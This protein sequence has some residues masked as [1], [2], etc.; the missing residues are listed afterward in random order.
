MKTVQH[1]YTTTPDVKRVF[2]EFLLEAVDE[3]LSALGD[4]AKQ[5][6]FSCLEK[7]FKINKL[8][9]PKKIDEFSVAIEKIFGQGARL[10][11][12]NIIRR[13]HEK[14]GLASSVYRPMSHDLF[15]AEYIEAKRL[16]C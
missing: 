9:I 15:F 3:E 1:K 2:N 12:I 6:V 11:E 14:V 16:A 13:L 8:E 7:S 4:V 10:I 5:A